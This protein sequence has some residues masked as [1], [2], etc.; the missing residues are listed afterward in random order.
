M[1]EPVTE[2]AFMFHHIHFTVHFSVSLPL[3]G[4][5]HTPLL[6]A[7]TDINSAEGFNITL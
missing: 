7:E 6:G 1:P 4:Q 5:A 2:G 3:C